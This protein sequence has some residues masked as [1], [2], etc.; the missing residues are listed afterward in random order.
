[1]TDTVSVIFSFFLSLML[2]MS[3]VLAVVRLGVMS[4][5]GF[6][7]LFDDEYCAM[8]LNYAT[9]KIMYYTYPTGIDPSVVEDV[10]TIGE[11]ERDAKGASVAAL[12][13]EDYLPNLE[14]ME[15][16]LTEKV[17]ASLQDGQA[18]VSG[19]MDEVVSTYVD[20]VM[21]LYFKAMK[22]PGID[23]IAKVRDRYLR[24]VTMGLGICLV[25][26]AILIGT[27]RAIHHYLHRSLRY[28]AFATGG[29]SL[30]C[31]LAPFGL[32][33]SQI[34]LGLK[35][36]PQ[37]LYHFGVTAIER[38]LLLTILCGILFAVITVLLVVAVSRLRDGVV[39]RHHHHSGRHS[40][41]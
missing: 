20:E 14:D 25:L 28:V 5:Q 12:K 34:Y 15:E 13:G 38:V 10:F 3:A 11:V 8:V 2:A 16:R 17:S 18:E 29:A 30:M 35:L 4:E 40:R 36:K 41:V 39:H 33:V 31:L 1:M 21:A 37:H 9:D 27:I 26:A 19:E 24:Y 23:S 22:L 7:S 32:F 6:A